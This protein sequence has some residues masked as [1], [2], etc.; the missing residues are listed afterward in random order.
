[1]HSFINQHIETDSFIR[2]FLVA[3]A[4]V[5]FAAIVNADSNNASTSV[6]VGNATPSI[7][8]LTL[9]RT[10][11][12]LTENSSVWASSS[13]TVTDNNS[14]QDVATVTARFFFSST[15][16]AA[17]S[18]C[19]EDDRFC[20]LADNQQENDASLTRLN[21]CIA[22]TAS[23]KNCTGASDTTVV[24][25]CGFYVHYVARP[26]DGSAPDADLTAGIWTVAASATDLAYAS[27]TATNTTQ[28]VEVG[29]LNAL[30]LSGNISYPNTAANSD[31]GTTNQTVTVTNTGYTPIDSQ[32]SGDIMCTDYSTCGGNVID[33]SQQKFGAGPSNEDYSALEFTLAATA[34]P[35]TIEMVL[36]TTTATTSA[37]STSTYWGIAIPNGQ[38]TGDYTGQ[39]TFTAVAD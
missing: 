8:A 14:C 19:D 35:A 15:T 37:I 20:Y 31:T 16:N 25:D 28:Q 29:T 17:S 24:Y 21:R 1:M 33:E 36:G 6:T 39:N 13:F 3:V 30:N 27:T 7:T 38:A 32:V 10:T 11:V 5:S 12:T 9:E 23:G 4:I 2:I 34:S 18:Q 26:S 22:S